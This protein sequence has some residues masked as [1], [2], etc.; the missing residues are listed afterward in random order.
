MKEFHIIPAG[1]VWE[2][3]ELEAG[4]TILRNPVK[5]DLVVRTIDLA[6]RERIS[7]V[8]IHN[9]DGSIEREENYGKDLVQSPFPGFHNSEQEYFLQN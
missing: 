5:R 7:K 4:K 9:F 1:C 2:A 3:K 8:V 6:K